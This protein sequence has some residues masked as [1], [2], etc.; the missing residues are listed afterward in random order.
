[1]DDRKYVVDNYKQNELIQMLKINPVKITMSRL[2]SKEIIYN[3]MGRNDILYGS[4]AIA[5]QVGG[6]NA[7]QPN[8]LDM[9][10]NQYK[11]RAVDINRGLNRTAGTSYYYMKPAI[12]QGTMKVMSNGQDGRQ[13]TR[14][15]VNIIDITKPTKHINYVT[16]RGR[17]YADIRDI[18]KDKITALNDKT[19]QFRHEKD[20]EDLRYINFSLKQ[21]SMKNKI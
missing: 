11:K 5:R 4:E 9:Y 17:R 13:G 18:R 12:H 15:D 16:I 10:S 14:D 6:V 1:M 20:K 2:K 7:R 19:Q 8:D 3:N 21:K